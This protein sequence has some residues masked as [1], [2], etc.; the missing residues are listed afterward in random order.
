MLPDELFSLL[1]CPEDRGPLF[2]VDGSHSDTGAEFLYNPR[3]K[4]RYK[5]TDG[6][7][8]LLIDAAEDISD[9]EAAE[10]DRLITQSEI[11]ASF[12]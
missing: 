7:A 8:E 11:K 5:I 9:T 6:I 10:L 12:T 3:L 1:A 4:R 2:L